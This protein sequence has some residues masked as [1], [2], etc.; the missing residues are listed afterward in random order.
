VKRYN[1][2]Y[3]TPPSQRH[4]LL[5]RQQQQQLSQQ[6]EHQAFM[7]EIRGV[8]GTP[9]TAKNQFKQCMLIF[10]MSKAVFKNS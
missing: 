3:D 4:A 1:P 5:Q 10:K 7:G 6:H 9:P 2:L 8:M